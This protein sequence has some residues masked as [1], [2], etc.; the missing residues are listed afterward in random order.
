MSFTIEVE[1]LRGVF[2]AG[3]GPHRSP[4]Q[5]PPSPAR[6]FCALV[7]AAGDDET[8]DE[9]LRWLERQPPPA[10]DACDQVADGRTREGYVP[11][12]TTERATYGRFPARKAGAKQ[13]WFHVTPRDV[14]VRYTWSVEPPAEFV[15][16]LADLADEV[17]YFGRSSSPAT[18]RLV[19]GEG[20]V[21]GS[22]LPTLVPGG[23]GQ[24]PA[25]DVPTVG[26][27]EALRAAFERGAPP[28][29]VTRRRLRYGRDQPAPD[30]GH[31]SVF[32]APFI[33]LPFAARKRV[34]AA[35]TMVVS[36]FV[37]KALEACLD[38][39][40]LV[41]RG[42]RAGE[43]RPAQQ[44]LILVL[45]QVGSEH[46]SGLAAGIA[47]VLPT[48]VSDIDRDAIYRGLVH[49][50]ANGV[51]A[52]KLG[53]LWFDSQ[54]STLVSLDPDAW[55]RPARRW[56]SATP[57]TLD[58]FVPVSQRALVER[59]VR[60]ACGF[61][62]LPE[63]IEVEFSALPLAV[64]APQVAPRL[65]QRRPGEPALPSVHVRLS[66]AERVEGPVVLGNLRRY[67]LGLCQ[68]EPQR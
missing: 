52:G 32:E 26:Y 51:A 8:Y 18:M 4:A 23:L 19:Q 33:V 56:V 36:R 22:Q 17:P 21:G 35:H 1:F 37:R 25:L 43:G 45:P 65:R 55:T 11:L 48:D 6:L 14:V 54:V 27:L 41:L 59:E 61:A 16:A 68:P 44:V 31:R 13:E 50:E 42:A 34:S 49:I 46:S 24:G 29:E 5:W 66:F 47:V 64:G 2:E 40:P 39:G 12:N 28:Y 7:A 9:A 53:R 15:R 60:R 20:G 62:G 30:P 63:P 10:I 57:M 58:R 38:G 3:E 67:G